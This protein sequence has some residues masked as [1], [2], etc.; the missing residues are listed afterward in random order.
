MAMGTEGV[1]RFF[2]GLSAGPALRQRAAAQGRM[3][4]MREAL[5]GAQIDNT[6][7]DAGLKQ[8]K[9]DSMDPDTLGAAMAAMGMDA[10][11]SQG[12]AGL[13]RAGQNVSEVGALMSALQK[14]SAQRAARDAALRG[15]RNAANANLFGVAD[16]PVDLSQVTDGVA[17][18]P[19]VTPDQNAFI[20][21]A[22]GQSVINAHNAAASNSSA[23][24]AATR[25]KLPV[26]LRKLEA[27]AG[28]ATR[29]SATDKLPPIADVTAVLPKTAPAD[30]YGNPQTNPQ[31]V[32]Q[33]ISWLAKNPGKSVGDY[34]NQA[35]AGS[36]GVVV[37][38]DT[39]VLMAAAKAATSGGDDGDGPDRETPAD[40]AKE[41]RLPSA[42]VPATKE[43][44]AMPST[45]AEFD[46]LPKG[47]L[48]INPADGRLLRK[49]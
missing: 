11:Q 10:S 49:K 29:S 4:A 32:A 15:D 40:N 28:K 37:P 6:Q 41:A 27:E 30:G 34:V 12:A 24:A 1:A 46:A 2:A 23:S 45:Q 5:T 22:V 7:A 26:E 42:T 38:S 19:T 44:P 3:D 31:D 13:V 25:A 35:P 16:K 36:P 47:A 21:T 48:F 33:V 17:L 18:D 14:Q 43:A 9:L 39:D 20:P 8:L